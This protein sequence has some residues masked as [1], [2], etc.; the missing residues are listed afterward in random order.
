MRDVFVVQFNILKTYLMGYTMLIYSFTFTCVSE[1][2]F[3]CIY[4]HICDIYSIFVYIYIVCVCKHN[5]L[6]TICKYIQFLIFNLYII[7]I[8]I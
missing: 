8:H 6:Y 3:V 4:I 7:H 5:V 1:A 2:H